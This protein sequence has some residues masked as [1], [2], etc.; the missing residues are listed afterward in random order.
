MTLKKGKIPAKT[1]LG[2][3]NANFLKAINEGIIKPK[4]KRERKS[5]V[6][7]ISVDNVFTSFHI[8]GQLVL[9][10]SGGRWFKSSSG[11]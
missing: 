4:P 5:H 10:K 9:L 2:A 6:F 1:A 8:L 11:S 3:S 7:M